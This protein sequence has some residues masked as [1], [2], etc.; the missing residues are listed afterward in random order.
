MAD[1][2]GATAGVR[3]RS[4]GGLH[5]FATLSIRGGTPDQVVVLL[6]GIPLNSPLGGGVDLADI[7]LTGVESIEVHRGFTPASIGV[8]SIGGAVSI[9]TRRPGAD[10]ALHGSL[11]YGS[12]GTAEATAFGTAETGPVRWVFSGEGSTTRG[13]FDYLDDNGTPLAGGD[14]GYTRRRNNE[15]WAAALRAHGEASLGEGRLLSLAAEW[16]GREQGVPGIDAYQSLSASYDAAPRAMLRGEMRW[17]RLAGSLAEARVGLDGEYASSSYEDIGD[18]VGLSPVDTATRLQATGAVVGLG[19]R[20]IAGHRISLLVQPRAEAATVVDRIDEPVDPFHAHRATVA[21]VVEDEIHLASDRVVLAPSLRF[22][23]VRTS[24]RGGGPSAP[25]DPA[26]D[27]ADVSGRLGALWTLSPRWS[28]RGNVGRAYRIPSLLELYG[29]SGTLLGNP[30]LVPES[31][32]NADLGVAFHAGAWG[33]LADLRIEV[34]GFQSRTEDLIHFRTL[35]TRQVKAM[36]VGEARVTGVEVA[37]SLRLFERLAL[38]GNITEQHP[39][40]R[41]DTF[42]RGDDLAG[43]PR[44][45][46][47]TSAALDLDPVTLFHRFTYVGENLIEDCGKACSTLPSSRREMTVIPSRY[48]HD[49]GV[50]VR[51][52]PRASATIEVDNLFDRHVVDV[53]RYPLPGRTVIVKLEAS[54]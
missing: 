34:A 4:W 21:A 12:W 13:D 7:P 47:A 54:F 3:V 1:L 22:D 37:A 43:V 46:A 38:S 26:E 48:L 44:R 29:N 11:A 39:E 40:N 23:A 16:A 36:N 49:A 33:V 41:S 32:V 28:L 27:P 25:P 52:G 17:S 42:A 9:R 5:S 50:K 2:L 51:M 18:P 10:E 31:G 15:S 6:D 35:P 14:D 8:S 20:P 45:E 30:D 24:A 53:V 19:W